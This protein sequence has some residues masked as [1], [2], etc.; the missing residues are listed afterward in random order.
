[1]PYDDHPQFLVIAFSE[2]VHRYLMPFFGVISLILLLA[3]WLSLRKSSAKQMR[4]NMT[5]SLVLSILCI[6][7]SVFLRVQ[8]LMPVS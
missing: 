2:L 7:A 8:M 6:A 5:A 1:M 3:A 4:D